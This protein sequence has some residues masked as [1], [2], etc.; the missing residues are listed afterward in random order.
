LTA[1]TGERRVVADI[2]GS[3][4]TAERLG[5]ERSK[6]L[7]DEVVRLMREYSGVSCSNRLRHL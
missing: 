6:F 4:A 3:T 5:P 2:A 1:P 7:L